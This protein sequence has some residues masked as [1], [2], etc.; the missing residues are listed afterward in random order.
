MLPGP[1][2]IRTVDEDHIKLNVLLPEEVQKYVEDLSCLSSTQIVI[3]N[4]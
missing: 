4:G 1:V 2:T 3:N